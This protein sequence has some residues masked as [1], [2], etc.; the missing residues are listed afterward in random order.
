MSRHLSL[1]PA[2]PGEP[3]PGDWEITDEEFEFAKAEAI[4]RFGK[5]PPTLQRAV[6]R[7][8]RFVRSSRRA[9]VEEEFDA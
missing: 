2:I 8:G 5:L 9:R 3:E 4:A 6:D 1:V 7:G